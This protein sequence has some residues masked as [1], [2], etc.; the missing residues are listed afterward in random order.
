VFFLF[1]PFFIVRA[2]PSRIQSPAPPFYV[3][4]GNGEIITDKI[5]KG[6]IV[7][8]F[9]EK[10][11]ITRK[12]A[13]MKDKLNEIFD[14]QPDNIKQAIIRLPVIDCSGVFWPVTEIWKK[15]LRDSSKRVGMAVYCDWS[16]NVSRNF[17]MVADE[18]NMLILDRK[19]TIRYRFSG[20]LDENMLQEI[21]DTLRYLVYEKN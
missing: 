5:I 19:S 14:R 3:E 16:G 21:I 13:A 4:S 18:S 20:K 12:N 9:Y 17:G 11:E 15:G 10:R 6:K 7:V 8:M 1:V 2:E